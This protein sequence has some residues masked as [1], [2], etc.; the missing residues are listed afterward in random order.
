MSKTFYRIIMI[1]HWQP[2]IET[3]ALSPVQIP[4]YPSGAAGEPQMFTDATEQTLYV[5]V[6]HLPPEAA[7]QCFADCVERYGV[8]RPPSNDIHQRRIPNR[9]YTF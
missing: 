2:P 7:Q 1:S 6:G 9:N 8:V 3:E 4:S 5:D